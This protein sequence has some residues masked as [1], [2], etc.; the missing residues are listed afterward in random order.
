MVQMKAFAF[1]SDEIGVTW[2]GQM[3]SHV[4]ALIYNPSRSGLAIVKRKPNR[5]SETEQGAL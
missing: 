1:V 3:V 5:V 2:I 4:G